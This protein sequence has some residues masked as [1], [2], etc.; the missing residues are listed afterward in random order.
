MSPSHVPGTLSKVLQA[1]D[2]QF[3]RPTF[4]TFVSLVLGWV[5]CRERHTISRVILAARCTGADGH[6]AR[7]YRFF[8]KSVW[9]AHRDELGL[10]VLALMLPL[11]PP[12]IELIVDDTLCR[13]GGPQI[14]GAAMHHDAV[15]SSYGGAHGAR[16]V[17]SF[18]HNWVVLSVRVPVPWAAGRAI[19]VPL[20]A[21]LYRGKKR[22]PKGQYQK[23]TELAHEM[24]ERLLSWLPE[25][26][27]VH[28][29]GDSEYACSTLVRSLPES[30]VFVG[31]VVMDAALDEPPPPY[32]GRGRPRLRGRRLPS[33]QLMARARKR[34]WTPVTVEIYGRSVDLLVQSVECL[35]WTVA[36]SRLVRVVLAR[37]P[38]GRYAD[39][40]FFATDLALSPADILTLIAHRWDLEV[41]FR[42]LKQHLGL[43]DPQ[44]GW[45]RRPA[46][47]RRKKKRAGPA[48]YRLRS[49]NAVERTVPFVLAVHGIVVAW[50]L[51][52]GHA[53]ADVSAVRA[54]APWR[55]RKRTP[56][57]ADMLAALRAEIL[58]ERLSQH[59]LP[60]RVRRKVLRL[61][62]PLC[63]AA[64]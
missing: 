50:Y 4:R 13:K 64:A 14:F 29:L 21:R 1:F 31:P 24:L 18:G 33:P 2:D 36:A 11:L 8:S 61:F 41:T 20:L 35:W 48:P 52:D 26:R 9:R 43:A 39:R 54:S 7:F 47:E 63:G 6:H 56:S 42:D 53:A 22:T 16:R 23:R 51:R 34:G 46:G 12:T 60:D 45:W 30:V 19:A 38:S 25:D 58:R 55:T 10:R 37:D 40:A 3:G 17:L 59:P 5:L 27:T 28:L 57:F 44:N 32:G 15:A 49:Q 62:L